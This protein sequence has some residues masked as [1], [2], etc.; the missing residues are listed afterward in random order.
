M[1][2]S[3]NSFKSCTRPDSYSMVVKAAVEPETKTV[4][5]PCSIFSFSICSRTL[6]VMSMMS[7]KPEVFCENFLMLILITRSLSLSVKKNR[8][9]EACKTIRDDEKC[10]DG[11]NAADHFD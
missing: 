6:A 10:G 7:Q 8:W 2:F 5:S 3:T 4:T 11:E 1:N 9:R